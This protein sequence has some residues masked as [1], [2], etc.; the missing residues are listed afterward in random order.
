MEDSGT[1]PAGTARGG[2]DHAELLALAQLVVGDAADLG[3]RMR[4]AGVSTVATKSTRTDVVTAADRAVERHVINAL[5]AARPADAVLGEEYGVST[6]EPATVRWILD[7]IDGTVNYLYGLPQYAVSLAAEVDG[8]V[9][10]G[11]VHNIATG[12][13]WW[14]QRG[15]GAYVAHW[16]EGATGDDYPARG[17]RL[18]GSTQR[19]LTQAL[20]ATGFGYDAQVRAE[21]AR[22]LTGLL[23]RVRDIRRFGAASL[24]LCM[25]AEGLVDGYYERGLAP[26]DRAAGALI[27]TEA[28]LLVTGLGGAPAGTELVIAAPPELHRALDSLLGTL[29]VLDG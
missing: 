28:G 10:V 20:I 15:A 11:V 27:A 2:P 9:V 8:E 24:D 26:W 21:Q 7:P 6:A 23:P 5:R 19:D 22:V 25:A 18:V 29:G 12:S 17:R 4:A 16:A 3:Y 1:L 14:A 13:R